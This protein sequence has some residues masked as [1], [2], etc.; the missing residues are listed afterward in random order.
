MAY[1]QVSGNYVKFLRGTPAAW[2]SIE[3]KDADTLY[4]IAEPEAST[5]LLYL[6]NKLISGNSGNAFTLADL[7][8]ILIEANIPD[9]ALLV[10]DTTTQK[11]KPTALETAFA[12]VVQVMQGAS[13]VEDGLAGLV[14][15]PVKGD[16]NFF[17]RGDGTWANPASSLSDLIDDRF[18]ILYGDDSGSIRDIASELI[19]ELIGNAPDELDTLE[20]LA[21]WI[22]EHDD[23]THTVVDVSNLSK[24]MFGTLE[25]PAETDA[26]LVS[27]VQQDGVIRIL[28]NL[29]NIVL[30]DTTGL[31]S[32]VS[33]NT[34]MINSLNS[35]MT[36]VEEDLTE[37]AGRLRW[38]DLVEE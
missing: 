32:V 11:W 3:S 31:Q 2:A 38:Q 35:R 17:L 12:S 13:E 5:G 1:K 29:Q 25:N 19:N 14:P 36:T 30:N 26:Q 7:Q 8:D 18:D 6:G 22:A 4:F 23:A 28:S 33:N 34:S 24:A 10:Y 27:M 9:D 21:A 20:E 15:Q 37:V 16:Q